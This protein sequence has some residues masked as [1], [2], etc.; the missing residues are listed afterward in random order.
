M[1]DAMYIVEIGETR[2]HG[3]GNLAQDVNGDRS[4]LLVDIVQGAVRDARRDQKGPLFASLTLYPCTPYYYIGI[5]ANPDRVCDANLPHAD[6]RVRQI[7]T[8][9]GDNV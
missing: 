7:G 1:N 8:V 2:H 5:S 3:E 4:S 9:K 6:M